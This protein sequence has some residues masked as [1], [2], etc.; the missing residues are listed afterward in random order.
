MNN[1][2]LMDARDDLA[3]SAASRLASVYSDAG[4]AVWALW[5]PS[6]TTDFDAPDTI[7]IVGELQRDATT[8]VM[9]AAI[10]R[11]LRP[12]DAVVPASIA[13]VARLAGGEPVPVPELGE[14][15]RSP[16]LAA[17]AV[18]QGDVAVAC[19]YTFL[20]ERDCGIYAV[21]TLPPWR[22]RGLAGSLLEHVLADAA[23]RGAHTASLQSTATARGLYESFGFTAAGRYEEWISR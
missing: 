12:H 2:I 19:A 21:G 13:A 8:L 11:G 20:H 22:R 14:P 5:V 3:A 6:R 17:W 1:A 4:V 23:A 16:G 7:P 18:V 9:H 15:E 10:P